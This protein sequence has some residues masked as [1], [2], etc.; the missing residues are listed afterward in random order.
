MIYHDIRRF[1]ATGDGLAKDTRP[2]Q[3][4]IDA[5]AQSGGGTVIVPAGTYL[6]GTLYLRDHTTL[7]LE[8][9]ATI[10]GSPD[11]ADY[12]TDDAYPQ[13]L[14]SKEENWTGAHLLIALEARH[15][16]L[17][18][19]GTIDGNSAAFFEPP[20]PNR[21]GCSIK[22]QRPGQMICF[23][24]CS[25]V[26]IRDVHLINAP[27]WTLFLHGCESCVV[28]GIRIFNPRGTPTGDG[29]DIDSCRDVTV[30]DCIVRSSD[31][32]ITLRGHNARLKKPN[33]ACENVVI[34]NCILSS[35]TCGIR[36]GVGDGIVRNCRVSNCV[37]TDCRTGIHMISSFAARFE[38]GD[39]KGC[40]I[41]RIA[42]SDLTVDA[43]MPF[44]IL[45]GDSRT[46]SIRDVSFSRLRVSARMGGYIAS[47]RPGLISDLHFS[48]IDL[49][50]LEPDLPPLP[51]E[52]LAPNL[53]EWNFL[54]HRLPFGI[55]LVNAHRVAFRHLSLSV[56]EGPSP[57]LIPF[58]MDTCQAVVFDRASLELPG[59]PPP[60]PVLDCP[61]GEPPRFLNGLLNGQPLGDNQP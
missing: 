56:A 47:S 24:E 23:V 27:S 17:T 37:L 28:S 5:C 25:H 59:H 52:R 6:C 33:R 34:S 21:P 50:F 57:R 48:D 45:S 2:I 38:G 44:W 15:V 32:S 49:D 40:T 16:A 18:G 36:V 51:R 8:P 12:N 10:R 26:T 61:R 19:M 55:F 4:A 54:A 9:G 53:R 22:T 3:D 1:G 39:K 31:D 20:Q 46:A 13:N 35:G 30:S 11:L 29:L 41:E 58:G 14:S 60:G 7:H 43:K 42:F